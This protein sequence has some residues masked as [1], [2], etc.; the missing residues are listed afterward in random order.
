MDDKPSGS[1]EIAARFFVLIMIAFIVAGAVWYGVS[2]GQWDR[3]VQNLRERPA[4]PLAFR[5]ILQPLM[6]IIAAAHDGVQDARLHRSPYLWS[7]V[8]GSESRRLQ[9]QESLVS[10]GRLMLI[11]LVVDVVY[12]IVALKTFFPGEAVVIAIVLPLV[13]YVLMRGPIAR[14]AARWSAAHRNPTVTEP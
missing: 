9:I 3:F 1:K 2:T 6:A 8:T 4:G 13:P 12:Q 14:I 5:F 7:I 11:G 10:T